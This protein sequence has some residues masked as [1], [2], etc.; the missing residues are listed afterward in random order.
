MDS[1]SPLVIF[2]CG[3]VGG[4]LARAALASASGSRR[5]RACARNLARLEPLAA[6]GAE[7]RAF[8]AT[9]PKQFGPA[10]MGLTAPTVVYSIPPP[11]GFPAGEAVRRAASASPAAGARAARGPPPPPP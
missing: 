7:V 4:Y 6:A 2:G 9:K 1:A 3:Y 5:V 8:D 10:L 11:P